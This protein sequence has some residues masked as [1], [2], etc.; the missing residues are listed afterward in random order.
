MSFKLDKSQIVFSVVCLFSLVVMIDP[1]NTYLHLKDPLFLL[2]LFTCCAFFKPSMSGFIPI[3]VA[4]LVWSTSSL[5]GWI[6]GEITDNDFNIGILKSFMPLILIGWIRYLNFTDSLFIPCLI[7]A[8][9]SI[10]VEIAMLFFPELEAFC[11]SYFTAENGLMMMSRRTFVGI[12]FSSAFYR[13]TPLLSIA[14][15]VAL[16]NYFY[17]KS[18]VAAILWIVLFLGLFAG[19]NRAC[20]LSAI[21]I[22]TLL[23][24]FRLYHLKRYYR[25]SILSV[26][27]ITL[28]ACILIMLLNDTQESS[29][30]AKFGHLY[31]YAKLF[32]EKPSVFIV[33]QGAGAVFYSEGFNSLTLQTEWTYIELIRFFGLPGGL[34]I[35]GIFIYPLLYVIRNSKHYNQPLSIIVGYSFYLLIAGTNPLLLSSTGMLACLYSYSYIYFRKKYGIINQ[36]ECRNINVHL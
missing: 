18:V 26:I 23:Y 36:K 32:N 27:V 14:L 31:S 35:V 2:L 25:F 15:A 6:D 11:Y 17:K 8:I 22:C 33:G 5:F 28:F 16:N 29:N 34:L 7:V 30:V 9:I 19:G 10:I 12:N 4:I 3:F 13:S 24:L 1:P 21:G 20:M